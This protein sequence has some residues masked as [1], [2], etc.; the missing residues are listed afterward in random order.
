MSYIFGIIGCNSVS[1]CLCTYILHC[2][3]LTYV[4]YVRATSTSKNY[5]TIEYIN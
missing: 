4:R 1:I 2:T 5:K 3:A